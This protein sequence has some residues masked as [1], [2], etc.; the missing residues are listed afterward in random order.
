[1]NFFHQLLLLAAMFA[2]LPWVAGA[3]DSVVVFNEVHYH[4]QN[5]DSS[6][7]YVELYNQLAIELDIS[8]WRLDG[9][10]EF[11]FPEG[12]IIPGRGYLVV[13]KNPS[14]LSAA[15][16]YANAL[17]PFTKSLSNSGKAIYLYNNNLSFRSQAGSGSI[18]EAT[19]ELE[20]RRIMDELDYRDRHPWP[21]GPDGSGFT[22]AKREPD[23]GTPHPGNWTVSSQMNGT[24]GAANTFAAP[25]PLSFNEVTS[26]LDPNFRIELHNHGDTPVALDQL[27]IASSNALSPDYVFPAGNLA[28]G[29]FLTIYATTLGFASADNVLLFLFSAGKSMVIDTARVDDSAM[30][31][32]PDGIGKWSRP[33]NLTL[34]SANDVSVEDA[35]VINEIFYHAKPQIASGSGNTTSLQVLDYDSVWRYNLSAGVNGLPAGWANSAHPADGTNWAAGPGLLGFENATLG[36]P[37]RTSLTL[38]A[39]IPYYFETEF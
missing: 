17:G 6:L 38:S 35:I 11:D 39:K 15:T 5:D 3:R 10:I 8:N 27:V 16:G 29:D 25:P 33:T 34:G 19:A 7:E 26:S 31:R 14:A 18:G 12:T 2:C 24:P 20:G 13:A 36:E 22:L 28:A 21:L 23:T 30:A 4:P 32:A 37:L 1:M 9:E